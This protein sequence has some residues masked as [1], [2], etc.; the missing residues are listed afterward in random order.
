MFTSPKKIWRDFIL[1]SAFYF[2]PVS[3]SLPPPCF[4]PMSVSTGPWLAFRGSPSRF[5]NSSSLFNIFDFF[6][7][8]FVFPLA[9]TATVG[10][11]SSVVF[12]DLDGLD[13]GVYLRMQAI[14][15][16]CFSTSWALSSFSSSPFICY[17]MVAP[18]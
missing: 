12:G 4:R 10:S 2:T 3:T 18:L 16:F 13:K 5:G 14:N 11:F 7:P 15:V 9:L 17:Y 6:E 8:F 1:R